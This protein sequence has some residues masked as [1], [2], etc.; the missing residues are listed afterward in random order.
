MKKY[1]LYFLSIVFLGQSCR[2]KQDSNTEDFVPVL[3]FIQNDIADVDTSLYPIIKIISVDS[4][5]ADTF[6]VKREE[7]RGLAKE[8]LQIPDL[9]R[10]K[11]RNLFV[12][13]K[14]F[15]QSL[16]TVIITYRPIN[17]ENEEIQRQEI[18]ITPVPEGSKVKSIIIDRFIACKDSTVQ[19]RM[20]WQIGKSFQITTLIQKSDTGEKST[21]LKVVWNKLNNY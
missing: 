13:E 16:N 7:F 14:F 9:T 3:P 6:F 19:K 10:K 18:L 21:T 20:L 2:Q 17:S 5:S 8:F 4:L 12:E 1:L 15:D 11:Y